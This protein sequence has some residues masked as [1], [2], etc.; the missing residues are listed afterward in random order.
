MKRRKSPRSGSRPKWRRRLRCRFSRR[1]FNL[2]FASLG[3]SW[4]TSRAILWN[5]RDHIVCVL[6]RTRSSNRRT[7]TRSFSWAAKPACRWCVNSF[8][9]S[10][11]VQISKESR[12]ASASGR[13]FT[14]RRG[15]CSTPRKIPTKRLRWVRPCQAGDPLR[16]VQRHAVAGRDTALIGTGDIRR[17]HERADPSELHHS[18]QSGR[19]VHYG[20]GRSNQHADPC[21]PGRARAS[22]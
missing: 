9:N 5:G 7:S 6:W 16:R 1:T 2:G 3:P 4:R 20:C 10:F 11:N 19:S 18:H 15:R 14:G 17:A 21:A 12:A 8:A 13:T 22:E